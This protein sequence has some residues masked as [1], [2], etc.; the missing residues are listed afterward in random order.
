[1]SNSL[2]VDESK[3]VKVT[4]KRNRSTTDQHDAEAGSLMDADTRRAHIAEAAYFR[5]EQRGFSPGGEQDDWY[6]A[7]AEIEARLNGA[8][9]M[10]EMH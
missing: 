9:E 7:E 8:G 6:A 10:A 5:A 4:R 3:P 1:M 2:I